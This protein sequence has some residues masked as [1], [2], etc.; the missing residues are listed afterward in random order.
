MA[1]TDEARRRLGFVSEP[2]FKE[3]TGVEYTL[4]TCFGLWNR[5]VINW[6]GRVLGCCVNF[7]DD[8]GGN[9][10]R[11]GLSASVNGERIT[12]QRQMLLGRRPARDD[13]PCLKCNLFQSMQEDGRWQN[14]REI[15]WTGRRQ[16]LE[17]SAPAM[18]LRHSRIGTIL[19]RALGEKPLKRPV[20]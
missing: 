16:R 18:A 20:C 10:F 5:P 13:M 4:R 3:K 17:E 9:A 2:E 12:Y 8:L 15:R 6:D 1:A 7:W 11:D 14:E 19:W